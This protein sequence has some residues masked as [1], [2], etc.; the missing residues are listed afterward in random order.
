[1]LRLCRVFSYFASG[2]PKRLVMGSPALPVLLASA[3]EWYV[4]DIKRE[5]EASALIRF[6]VQL[7]PA[8]PQ[9]FRAC[10]EAC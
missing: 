10:S 9:E 7:I 1:M 3:Q 5:F 6:R 2:S 4:A 8:T